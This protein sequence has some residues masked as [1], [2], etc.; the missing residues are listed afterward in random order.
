MWLLKLTWG[1]QLER[2][3]VRSAGVGGT[4]RRVNLFFSRYWLNFFFNGG[5]KVWRPCVILRDENDVVRST[6]TSSDSHATVEQLCVTKVTKSIKKIPLVTSGH[7]RWPRSSASCHQGAHILLIVTMTH[8]TV[9]ISN[10]QIF[11]FPPIQ[12]GV[13]RWAARPV[14]V[15]TSG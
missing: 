8:F 6:V 15:W 11:F 7:H 5:G 13:G 9:R 12:V 3:R 2:R 4:S 14:E 1:D 10:I